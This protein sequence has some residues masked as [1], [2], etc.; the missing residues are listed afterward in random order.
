MTLELTVVSSAAGL[1][2]LILS[3]GIAQYS[4]QQMERPCHC[5]TAESVTETITMTES[6][7]AAAALGLIM[8]NLVTGQWPSWPHC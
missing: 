7:V 6:A 2:V 4:Q 1:A 8:M 3:E 5:H